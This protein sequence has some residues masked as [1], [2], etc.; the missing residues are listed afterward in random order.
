MALGGDGT[1]DDR[2]VGHHIPGAVVGTVGHAVGQG[3]TIMDGE[4]V[5]LQVMG[6]RAADGE[7]GGG[8]AADRTVLVVVGGAD[9]G[10]HGI[11]AD[12]VHQV[13]TVGDVEVDLGDD[14]ATGNSDG[15]TAL[16]SLEVHTVLVGLAGGD[17]DVVAAHA[18][19]LNAGEGHAV[20]LD[21]ELHRAA[22]VVREDQVAVV[23]AEDG[24]GRGVGGHHEGQAR[25]VGEERLGLGDEVVAIGSD[26]QGVGV[27]VDPSG[28][29]VQL[30]G[31]GVDGQRGAVVNTIGGVGQLGDAF[32][33]AGGGGGDVNFDVGS[34]RT[35]IFASFVRTQI[36]R[37]GVI[38]V[39]MI[40]DNLAG[41]FGIVEVSGAVA[42]GVLVECNHQV[43]RAVILKRG[44]ERDG[45]P[46]GVEGHRTRI[47]NVGIGHRF[48]VGFA[49]ECAARHVLHVD[50][51]VVGLR[52]IS[53]SQIV[54][55]RGDGTG[56]ANLLGSIQRLDEG[57]IKQ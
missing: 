18:G 48:I 30:G 27:L 5:D 45:R 46:A 15:D 33:Q 12:G 7:L 44:V 50:N 16:A 25:A 34:I 10:T 37:V 17:G 26:L 11:G 49:R 35:Y 51:E 41:V 6:R 13:G 29:M 23:Q 20:L 19:G 3:V 42:G 55:D 39:R 2:G 53:F 52:L 4:L 1:H 14:S 9:G 57:V 47:D 22:G 8:H 40:G 43:A 38:A 56:R 31:V 28:H 36:V 21:D 24:G 54:A 32:G